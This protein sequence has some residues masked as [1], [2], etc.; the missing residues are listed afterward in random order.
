MRTTKFIAAI[1]GVLLLWVCV[2]LPGQAAAEH[3]EAYRLAEYRPL[4]QDDAWSYHHV[5]DSED[6]NTVNQSVTGVEAGDIMEFIRL[7]VAENGN[8]QL[9]TNTDGIVLYESFTAGD[10]GWTAF[11]YE[12]PYVLFPAEMTAGIS[13]TSEPAEVTRTLPEGN[14]ALIA[15]MARESV[16]EGVEEVTVPAGKFEDCLRILHRM[17]ITFANGGVKTCDEYNYLAKRVGLVKGRSH[18]TMTPVEGEVSTS[19]DSRELLSATVG[20]VTYPQN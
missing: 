17:T 11:A 19:N 2:G 13:Y 4:H 5:S 14:A 18:C 6:E 10:A 16:L 8:Y 7:Q 1:V 15:T 12:P 20:G 9:L 3:A